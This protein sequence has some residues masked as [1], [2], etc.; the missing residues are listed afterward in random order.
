MQVDAALARALSICAHTVIDTIS[1]VIAG[2]EGG[3]SY[4]HFPGDKTS[5]PA[6]SV[7]RCYPNAQRGEAEPGIEPRSVRLKQS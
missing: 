7:M 1:P 3:A 4:C 5:A 2:G 6:D